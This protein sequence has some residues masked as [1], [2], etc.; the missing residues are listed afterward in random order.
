MKNPNVAAD[1]PMYVAIVLSGP[2][3]PAPPLQEMVHSRCGEKVSGFGRTRE[4]EERR[5]RGRRNGPEDGEA[6]FGDEH[7]VRAG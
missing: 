1:V 5:E 6:L 3:A 4:R 7:Q 2:W